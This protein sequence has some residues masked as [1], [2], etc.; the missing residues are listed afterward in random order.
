MFF[1]GD[2]DMVARALVEMFGKDAS[3]HTG[4]VAFGPTAWRRTC[5]TLHPIVCVVPAGP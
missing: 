5:A 3:S 4:L 1:D 2:I